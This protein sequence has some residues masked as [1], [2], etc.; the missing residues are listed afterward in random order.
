MIYIDFHTH[1]INKEADV[2]SI[3]NLPLTEKPADFSEQHL[4]IGIHPW[5]I[6]DN[7][8]QFSTIKL[9]IN[10]PN[11]K[12]IGECGLD[13]LKGPDLAIQTE[14]FKQHIRWSEEF[15]KPLI[16]HCV[17][18]YSEIIKLRKDLKPKQ[19]W[20][21]HGFNSSVETLNQAIKTGFYFSFGP[22]ILNH[23]KTR[24]SFI[25]SPI[26]RIFLETDDTDFNIKELYKKAAD[27]KE[28]G[29]DEFQEKIRDNFN[30]ILKI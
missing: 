1:Q 5:Y 30:L 25:N 24:K 3:Y 17:K 4:S 16:I 2:K 6:N 8:N 14:V 7:N 22:A 18:A 9:N 10:H 29:I 21:F 15:E 12:A 11:V 23:P 13:K 26:N 27:L 28:T 20:I 19:T